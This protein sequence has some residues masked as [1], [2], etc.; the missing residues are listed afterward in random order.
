SAVKLPGG[1][2]GLSRRTLAPVVDGRSLPA[3]PFSPQ[4]TEVSRDV[5]LIIGTNK[6][7]WTLFMAMDPQFGSMTEAQARARFEASLGDKAGPAFDLYRA[8]R[9]NDPPTYWVTALMTDLMMRT[10]SIVEADRKSAQNA[11]PVFMYRLDWVTPV[12]GG[13][14]R[15]PH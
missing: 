5:P 7:E 2:V 8:A 4:A 15:S 3:H 12:G 13:A 14:L 10:N 9:P 1:G 6:D 11:A